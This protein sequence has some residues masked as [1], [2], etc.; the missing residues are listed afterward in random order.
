MYKAEN[1]L[2]GVNLS[3]FLVRDNHNYNFHS[4]SELTVPSIN[5]V[6]SLKFKILLVILDQ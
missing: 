1:N 5:T 2:P 4:R 3:E 6:L